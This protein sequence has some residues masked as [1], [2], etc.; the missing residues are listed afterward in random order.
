[1]I[2]ERKIENRR[3]FAECS[4][5]N[6]RRAAS[7]LDVFER[8]AGSGSPLRPGFQIRFGWSLFRLVEEADEENALRVTEPDFAA[9]P[10]ELWVPTIDRSLDV[11]AAQT[12]LLRGL[13]V[14]AEDVFFDQKLI[15]AP[16]ALAASG[17]FLRRG[18]RLSEEDSGWLL[19]TLEDPE[20]LTLGEGLEGVWVA[21]LVERRPALLQ[22]LVLPAG[23]IAIFSGDSI[24]QI[25]DA[26]GRELL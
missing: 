7:V 11:L 20:A 22:A 9:W 1:M 5:E 18:D 8:L 24:D 25:L 17:V 19:G 15:A 2:I 14:D 10:E 16:G 6:E 12:S 3:I 23:F 21:S 13:D 4:A 26:A